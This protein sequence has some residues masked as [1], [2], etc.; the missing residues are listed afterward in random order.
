MPSARFAVCSPRNIRIE[1]LALNTIVTIDFSM[2]SK[3]KSLPL[4]ERRFTNF[5]SVVD[6]ERWTMELVVGLRD[7]E[8]TSSEVRGFFRVF[9]PTKTG[10]ILRRGHDWVHTKRRV[11]TTDMRSGSD[12]PLVS[13]TIRT[14]SRFDTLR[15]KPSV[16]NK[17]KIIY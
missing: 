16:H 3:R 7:T 15:W 14:K 12:D 9:L 8:R 5:I 4:R 2:P 6:D 13:K 11:R 17:L 1:L 10:K